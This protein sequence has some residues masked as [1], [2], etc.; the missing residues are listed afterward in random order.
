MVDENGLELPECSNRTFM[1]L[2]YAAAAWLSS[3]AS[4]SNR[5]FMELKFNMQIRLC[6][7]T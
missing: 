6:T 3:N 5:T 7:R 2:K 4:C 1:E